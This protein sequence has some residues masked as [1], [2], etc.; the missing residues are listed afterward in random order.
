MGEGNLSAITELAWITFGV[1][2]VRGIFQYGQD[3]LMAKAALQAITDLRERV[4]AHLQSL[5]LASFASQR[6]GI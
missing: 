2:V 3:T 4:Y 5:D 1:F 6:T